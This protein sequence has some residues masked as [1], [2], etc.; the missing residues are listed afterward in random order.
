MMPVRELARMGGAYFNTVV[1][2][3]AG[4]LLGFEYPRST[5]QIRFRYVVLTGAAAHVPQRDWVS[6]HD[7]SDWADAHASYSHN[8]G[9]GTSPAPFFKGGK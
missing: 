7:L 2:G 4:L 5:G 6:S 3:R 8:C 1:Q 9:A